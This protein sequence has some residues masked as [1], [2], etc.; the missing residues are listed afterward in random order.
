MLLIRLMSWPGK[1]LIQQDLILAERKPAA[2]VY[3]HGLQTILDRDSHTIIRMS[4][5]SPRPSVSSNR[6]NSAV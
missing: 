1:G 3:G 2:L 6:G 5:A 4:R